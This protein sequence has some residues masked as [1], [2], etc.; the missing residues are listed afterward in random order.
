MINVVINFHGQPE[1]ETLK[2]FFQAVDFRVPPFGQNPVQILPVQAGLSCHLGHSTPG[3]N[4][5]S[6]RQQKSRAIT[7]FECGIQVCGSLFR[8]A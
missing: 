6:D 1:A 8:I 3:F 4:Y 7:L 5:I 2:E